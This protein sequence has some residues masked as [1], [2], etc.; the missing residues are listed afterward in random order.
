MTITVADLASP[1]GLPLLGHLPAL[2]RGGVMHRTLAAWAD[3]YG[4]TYRVRMGSTPAI[5]TASPAIVTT[6]LRERPGVFRRGRFMSDLISELG[7]DGLF[8]AEG[9]DWQRL[10]RIAMRGLNAGYLRD[11]YPTIA[12]AAARLLDHSAASARLD[13]ADLLRYTL[14]V[15][16][17]LFM[18]VEG[19]AHPGLPLLVEA[20]GRRLTSPV[21]YWRWVRLPSDRRVD[22]AATEFSAMI[23][24]RYADARRRIAAGEQPGNYLEALAKADLDG[25]ETVTGRDVVGTVLNMIVAGEDTTA[26]TL[27]WA[28]HLLATNPGMQA[29]VREQTAAVLGSDSLAA[30]PAVLARLTEAAEVVQEAIRRHPVAPFLMLEALSGTTLSDGTTDL[31]VEPG[32]LVLPLLTHEADLPFGSGPRFCPGRNLA[33]LE[34]TL[35]VAMLCHNFTLSPDPSAG[36]VGERVTFAVFPTNLSVSLA[37]AQSAS[38]SPN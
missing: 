25:E 31:R 7:A 38:R 14:E 16:T 2:A 11:S 34:S 12:R 8:N 24:E 20:L 9:A 30:D 5:V 10:R 32:T 23:E 22:A 29:R 26:A 28:V 37:P 13:L 4:P 33:L 27:G 17:G 35:I 19:G 1:P 21:P 3:Q 15:S 6:V 36:P 18:G